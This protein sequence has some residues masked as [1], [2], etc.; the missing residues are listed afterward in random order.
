VFGNGFW[1]YLLQYLSGIKVRLTGL[2]FPASSLPFL[3]AGETSALFHS[4]GR[5]PYHHDLPKMRM[6]SQ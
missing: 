2:Q 6:A 4:S 5:Y 1:D 3:K